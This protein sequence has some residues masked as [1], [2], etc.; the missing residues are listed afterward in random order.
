MKRI[1][2]RHRERG[3]LD[4]GAF[5]RLHVISV[6]F[7]TTQQTLGRDFDQHCRDLEQRVLGGVEAARLDVDDHRQKAAKAAREIRADGVHCDAKRQRRRS[8]ARIGT[9]TSAPNA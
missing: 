9:T 1:D 2:P 6:C 5:E 3:G 4:V 7:A 8:L